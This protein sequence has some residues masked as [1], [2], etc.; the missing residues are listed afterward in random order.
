VDAD[1]IVPARKLVWTFG[2]GSDDGF[3][4]EIEGGSFSA[5]GEQGGGYGFTTSL[6][7]KLMY[8]SERPHAESYGVFTFDGPGKH[9]IHLVMFDNLGEASLEF[10]HAPGNR[11]A[12][13]ASAPYTLVNGGKKDSLR[14]L[15]HR[16]GEHGDH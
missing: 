16:R 11:S 13:F 4:L 7:N 2:V 14:V 3:L 5:I 1:V 15:R 8:D 9:R 12:N 10:F 6:G